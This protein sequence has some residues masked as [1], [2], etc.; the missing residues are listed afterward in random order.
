MTTNQIAYWQMMN[1]RDKLKET[2][3]SNLANEQIKRD[4]L[5]ETIQHN[6]NTE[7]IDVGRLN[8]TITHNRNSEGID[9]SKLQ[10]QNR[11]NLQTESQAAL[12]SRRQYDTA[13]KN[14]MAAIHNAELAAS[15][16]R[17]AS[18]NQLGGTMFSSN[19]LFES[20]KYRAD[21]EKELRTEANNIAKWG[22]AI[23]QQGASTE[24]RKAD[25]LAQQLDEL[26]RHNK[27]TETIDW[28]DN[29]RKGVNDILNNS[30]SFTKS[31]TDGM[32]AALAAGL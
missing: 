19:N 6:R 9:L 14:I 8:E 22:T 4:T 16:S 18:D 21:I 30:M 12:D 20:A 3:R 2:Q 7:G 5:G 17:Y 31:L 1:D 32:N 10:E 25:I 11:H 27:G 29:I 28:F 26:I 15:A 24:A 23:K 13:L